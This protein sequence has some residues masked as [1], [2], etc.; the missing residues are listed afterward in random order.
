MCAAECPAQAIT[1]HHNLSEQ[2]E[3]KVYGLFESEPR[4]AGVK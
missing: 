3:A 1:V 2:I 4:K